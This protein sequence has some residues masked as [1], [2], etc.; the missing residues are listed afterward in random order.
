MTLRK[1]A[2]N[3]TVVCYANKQILF[4]Y[5]TP[6]AAWLLGKGYYRTSKFFSRTTLR[7]VSQW[8]DGREAELVDQSFLDNLC[9]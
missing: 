1:L 7:H 2:N 5:E 6:V 3:V 4:S 9:C 8:L